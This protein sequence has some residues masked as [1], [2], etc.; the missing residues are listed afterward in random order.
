MTGAGTGAGAKRGRGL[1]SRMVLTIRWRLFSKYLITKE[2]A[3]PEA[4]S[5]AITG[6]I[7]GVRACVA[8]RTGVQRS[9]PFVGVPPVSLSLPFKGR[10]WQELQQGED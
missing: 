10:F 8:A 4:T 9:L 5:G 2:L 3:E 1:A 7:A 6:A